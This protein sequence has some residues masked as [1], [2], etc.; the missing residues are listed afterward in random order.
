MSHE[1]NKHAQKPQANQEEVNANDVVAGNEE[2]LEY[3]S[4]SEEIEN[5]APK[6]VKQKNDGENADRISKLEEDLAKTKEHMLRSIA[7]AENTRKRAVKD[8]EDAYKFAVSKFARD[9]LG[10]AD[11]LRRALDAIP[12]ELTEQHP[13]IKN[14]ADGIEATERELLQ[15]FDKNGIKK[16]DP[17]DE[18][19]NPNFHEVMFETPV[20]NKKA[21]TVIQVLESGY[22]LNDRILRPAR[23]GVAKNDENSQNP[24]SSEPGQT[25]NTE[26]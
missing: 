22:T 19:F 9:L 24:S 23:V 13:Q 10:V 1:Q 15:A 8:R 21:G 14:L 6:A 17:L 5:N 20:P 7:E 25:I 18:M 11:N 2:T 12:P 16:T 26:V 3:E 4:F